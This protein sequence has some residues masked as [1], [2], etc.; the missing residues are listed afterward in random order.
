MYLMV[1][2]HAHDFNHI[3]KKYGYP[4]TVASNIYLVRASYYYHLSNQL[5]QAN[6]QDEKSKQELHFCQQTCNKSIKCALSISKLEHEQ[7]W[8]LVEDIDRYVRMLHERH[9]GDFTKL[10]TQEQGVLELSRFCE[11]YFNLHD[12]GSLYDEPDDIPFDLFLGKE[13]RLK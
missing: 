10:T 7:G 8:R 9:H 6:K 11:F 3:L 12:E 1:K 5:A 2:L 4:D 13:N